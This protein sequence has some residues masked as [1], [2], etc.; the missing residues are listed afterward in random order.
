MHVP[1]HLPH[2]KDLALPEPHSPEVQWWESPGRTEERVIQTGSGTEADQGLT[3]PP[4]TEKLE[5]PTKP[6][7][8]PTHFSP[9]WTPPGTAW[10]LS[11]DVFVCSFL[12]KRI[13]H[14]PP[15]HILLNSF[16]G[17]REQRMILNDPSCSPKNP[18]WK[19]ETKMG[20]DS[21]IAYKDIG[22]NVGSKAW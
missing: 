7:C 19:W 9:L 14:P 15:T 11:L 18:E 17:D 12:I 21:K 8:L 4:R 3:F 16:W 5:S 1:T 6:L 2:N 13:Y 10:P 20:Y 22:E